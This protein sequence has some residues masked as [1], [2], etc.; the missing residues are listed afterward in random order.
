MIQRSSCVS[1]F[2]LRQAEAIH[3]SWLPHESYQFSLS[4][5]IYSYLR[6]MIGSTFVALRAGTMH[7]DNATIVS[8]MDM[9]AN[10]SGSVTLTANN[11]L[12]INLVSATAAPRPMAIPMIVR[13][14]A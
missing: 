12:S 10:V 5:Y 13:V 11:K 8:T 14:I 3:A 7:A 6:A 9:R 1:S 2:V 4:C